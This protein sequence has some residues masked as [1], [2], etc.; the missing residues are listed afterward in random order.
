[1]CSSSCSEAAERSWARAAEA[2]DLAPLQEACRRGAEKFP[3]ML[4]RLACLRIQRQQQQAGRSS[5]SSSSTSSMEASSSGAA[6]ATAHEAAASTPADAPMQG[7]PLTQLQH[8]CYANLPEVPPPWVE[9][10]RLLLQGLRPLCSSSGAGLESGRCGSSGAGLQSSGGSGGG[11]S[12]GDGSSG[13]IDSDWLERTFSLQWFSDALSRLHLNSFRV[14]TV[15]PLD[16]SDPS[17][18]LRA[19]AASLSGADAGAAAHHTGSAAYLLA[20]M[21]NHSCEPNLDV[22]F[23]ENN[24]VVS[25]V[26]AR[27]ISAHEQLTISYVD[28]GM[29]LQQ[30]RSA[31]QFG[32]GF[33]CG[34]PRCKEEAAAEAGGSGSGV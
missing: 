29:G 9:L 25:F 15:P 30:R 19:A 21:L 7:D 8:L 28:T 34:C 10:H 16:A 11:G 31:L 2:A 20:S 26:A 3:L 6:P 27:D 17:A 22:T 12:G 13:S 33:T 4:A 5:S 24:A 32:Y 18:L 14:D 23:P 1:M